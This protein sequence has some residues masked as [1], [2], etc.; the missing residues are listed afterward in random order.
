MNKITNNNLVD[1]FE[2]ANNILSAVDFGLAFNNFLKFV[3]AKQYQNIDSI[4]SLSYRE[5]FEMIEKETND[6]EEE[7]ESME[8]DIKKASMEQILSFP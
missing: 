4:K 6:E 2:N 7:M 3:K 1:V 5:I 8:I